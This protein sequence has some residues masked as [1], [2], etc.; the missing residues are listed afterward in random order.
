M[1]RP[2]VYRNFRKAYGGDPDSQILRDLHRRLTAV[3][4][5][6]WGHT[7]MAN[8]KMKTMQSLL[9]EFGFTEER[10]VQEEDNE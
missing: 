3:E 7:E 6:F 9:D 2:P 5:A 4:L 8:Q 10:L 1:S